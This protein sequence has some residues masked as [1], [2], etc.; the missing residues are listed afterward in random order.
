MSFWAAAQ[1]Q[2]QREK[3]AIHCLG[4]AGY[5]VWLP[6]II[7]RR[8]LHG[9]WCEVPQPLFRGYMF[10]LVES[11]WHSAQRCP[12]V[13]RLVLNGERPARVPDQVIKAL[14][15]R[16]VGG[17]VKLPEPPPRLRPGGRVR[18]TGGPFRGHL[19]IG[20]RNGSPR[21]GGDPAVAAGQPAAGQRAGER[22]GADFRE[23]ED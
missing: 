8:R 15:E 22:R 19:G 7:E 18:V 23:G 10:V 6:Q 12:G 1:L 3:L 20:R 13:N 11:Q 14:K 2:P 5:A 17:F 4:L 16:E 9:R 21:P